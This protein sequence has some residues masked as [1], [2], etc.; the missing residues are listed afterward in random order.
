MIY[1][2]LNSLN[3]QPM[4]NGEVWKDILGW[5]GLYSVSSL[6][7]VKREE[8]SVIRCN[9]YDAFSMT[10][11]VKIL[12]ANNDSKGYPQVTLSAQNFSFMKKKSVARVHRLVAQAFHVN[13]ENKPQVN[14]I[15]A[16]RQ[17]ARVE[18]L[19]W[20]TASENQQHSYK[21]NGREALKGVDSGMSRYSE[22]VVL[23]V[24]CLAVIGRYSQEEIGR[25]Y[26]MPQITVSNIKT[27]KTWRHITDSL[28]LTEVH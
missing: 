14:H 9:Q 4:L 7:R 19:E 5:E 2:E 28:K 8:R 13:P 1:P 16:E 26:G 24:Y 3:E 22:G 23:A 25:M 17:D 27:K 11:P 18:N 10:Y 20:C 6:G 21:E 12:K 15:N